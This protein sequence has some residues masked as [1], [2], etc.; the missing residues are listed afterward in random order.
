MIANQTHRY[1]NLPGPDSIHRFEL[2]NGITLLAYNNNDTHSV[3]MVGLLD[4]GSNNDPTEKLGLAHFTANM[5]TRGTRTR[6]FSKYHSILEERGANLSF[7]CG[8]RHTWFQ[9]KALAEDIETLVDLCADSLINPSFQDPYVERLRKQLLASL[10]IRD[11]DSSEVASMLFDSLLFPNHPY[12][13]PVDGSVQSVSSLSRDDIRQFHHTCY[14]PKGMILAVSGAVSPDHIRKT[15]AQYF[16]S[17]EKKGAA[18]NSSPPLLSPPN[19]IIRK[20]IRLEEKSQTDLIMGTFGPTRTSAD[21]LP[22]YLGNHI[23][24]QFG[25]MGRIGERVRSRSGLA[26]HASSNL[27]AWSDGGSWEFEAGTNPDNL[28]RTIR[29]IQ[30]EIKRF[31]DSPVSDD[32]LEDSRSHLIGRLPLSLESNA[33][34]SNAILTM[35]RFQLGL[36]YYQNYAEYLHAITADGILETVRKYLH[37]DQLVITS[38]GAGEEV[39]QK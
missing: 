11:E 5:L 32:E 22:A 36:D 14:H 26:Y 17:W 10:A 16:S 3:H 37:P 12:G 15:V 2:P 35:E 28:D 29:L 4:C 25:L 1:K 38:A 23:L 20:H 9:G 39:P 8:A 33:G 18:P 7:S 21:Y 31:V 30:D 27:N 34:L 6:V 24:G 13:N 19:K